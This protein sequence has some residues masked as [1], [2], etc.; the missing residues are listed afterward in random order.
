MQ[1][2]LVED[3]GESREEGVIEYFVRDNE[4]A[5]MFV[6]CPGCGDM[7]ALP[8]AVPPFSTPNWTWDEN[9]E[10]PTLTPS[11]VH[12]TCGWHGWLTEG[13]FVT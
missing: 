12:K 7:F 5:G 13:E 6:N 1:A 10:K 11:I 4:I 8:F 2:C 9:K 3:I